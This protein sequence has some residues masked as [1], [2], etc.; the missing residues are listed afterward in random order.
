MQK[1]DL[2][3]T[4]KEARTQLRKVAIRLY[5]N[6]QSKASIARKLGLRRMTVINWINKYLATG[7]ISKQEKDRGRPT[8]SGRVLTPEQEASIQSK[9]IDK[10]P[11]QLKLDFALWGVKAVKLLIKSDFKINLSDRG[12]CLY[13]SRW[14]FTPQ[15]PIRKAYEQ[16]PKHV[17]EFLSK[18]Y[19]SIKQRAKKENAQIHWA[20]ETGLSSVEHYPRGY[21]PKGKTPVLTLSQATRERVNMIS[22][23]TNQGKVRFMLYPDKF[24]AQV[25]I[26]FIEQL[27]KDSEQKVFLILDNLRVHHAKLVKEFIKNKTHQIEL[28]Y[29]PSYSPE[30]NP[31]EYLNCDLKARMSADKPTRKKGEMK[32]KLIKHMRSLQ[33]QPQR[34]VSYFKHR[35]IAYAA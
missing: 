12:V 5:K 19:P 18:A 29:L 4:T 35:K 16:Q 34:V 28:F 10:T 6:N 2:R 17:K 9:I 11:D 22:S 15:R 20:D 7:T 21:A 32:K 25:F 3:T 1:I 27:I 31:D 8:Y 26:K 23:M 30:L 14:G 24:S 33:K 13:L